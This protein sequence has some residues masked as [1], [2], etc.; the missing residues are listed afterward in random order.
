MSEGQLEELRLRARRPPTRWHSTPRGEAAL[1][2]SVRLIP[3][4]IP[5]RKLV[6]RGHAG[7]EIV[8]EASGSGY[9]AVLLGARGL[10]RIGALVG[11]VSAHAMHN[12]PVPVFVAHEPASQADPQG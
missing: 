8:A 10:G 4:E 12:A 2:E 9:D 6:R 11:S 5:V 7:P 1:V 3:A